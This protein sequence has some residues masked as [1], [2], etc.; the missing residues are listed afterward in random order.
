MVAIAAGMS[1]AKGTDV[2]NRALIETALW[3]S[4]C[5][6]GELH[7][8]HVWTPFGERTLRRN[9]AAPSELQ[10]F[11]SGFHEQARQDLDATI[12]SF[13]EVIAPGRVHLEKGDPR[14]EIAR[15][16]AAYEADLLVVGTVA[17]KGLRARVIGNT[18]EALLTTMPCSMLVIKPAEGATR[19]SG[20]SA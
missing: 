3:L 14:I 11:V 4:E 8:V 20:A 5:Q 19:R 18:A 9:G 12:A 6:G 2:F 13:R 16:A 7:V 15:S 10:Q 17:R 1:S